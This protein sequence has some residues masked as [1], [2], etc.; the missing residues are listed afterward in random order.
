MAAHYISMYGWEAFC[1]EAFCGVWLWL[2][3]SGC[4][5]HHGTGDLH[6][7]LETGAL[8]S[9]PCKG[10]GE[11]RPVKP[12]TYKPGS[13]IETARETV[14]EDESSFAYRSIDRHGAVRDWLVE[15][16]GGWH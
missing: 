8:C 11:W 3:K 4:H 7:E 5:V 13:K 9:E 2:T 16:M 10:W 6:V 15:K 1:K 14:W 12:G